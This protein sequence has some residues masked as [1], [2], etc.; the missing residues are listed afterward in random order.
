MVADERARDRARVAALEA[1]L[2]ELRLEVQRLGDRMMRSEE[3]RQKY[4]PIVMELADEH[5]AEMLAE[6]KV[7]RRTGLHLT[8]LQRL[9]AVLVAA[10]AIGSLLLQ[11]FTRV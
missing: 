5:R 8:M 4:I 1:A 9:T 10:S 7:A 2:A 11:V 3:A 6:E